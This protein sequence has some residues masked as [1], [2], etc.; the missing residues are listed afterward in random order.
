MRNL[1][2][3]YEVTDQIVLADKCRCVL[4]KIMENFHNKVGLHDLFEAIAE[5][6]NGLQID[7]KAF[8]CEEYLD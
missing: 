3:E 6:I 2:I 5:W 1:C 8:V 4:A 7:D